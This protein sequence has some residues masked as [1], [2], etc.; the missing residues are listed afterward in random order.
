MTHIRRLSVYLTADLR[1]STPEPLR[2][3]LVEIP[4]EVPI[5]DD[6]GYMQAL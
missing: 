2:A 5:M 6:K 1:R 3:R 4:R